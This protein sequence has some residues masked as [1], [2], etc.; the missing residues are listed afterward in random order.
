MMKWLFAPEPEK[1][2]VYR[3]HDDYAGMIHMPDGFRAMVEAAVNEAIRHCRIGKITIK[4]K[5]S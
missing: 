5:A 2:K 1:P 4:E 3:N